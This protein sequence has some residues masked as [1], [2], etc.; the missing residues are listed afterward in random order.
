M[1]RTDGIPYIAARDAREIVFRSTMA[2]TSQACEVCL[3]F[4]RGCGLYV[5][6]SVASET[7][8]RNGYYEELLSFSRTDRST[9][10]FSFASPTNGG[11]V[12]N[13]PNCF[14]DRD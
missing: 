2:S 13:A 10:T 8:E 4:I 9:T 7:E 1:F 3:H 11:G 5:V 14:G 12:R 6:R